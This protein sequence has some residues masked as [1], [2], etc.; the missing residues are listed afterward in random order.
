MVHSCRSTLFLT[1]RL[2]DQSAARGHERA[3]HGIS[4]A[5]SRDGEKRRSQLLPGAAVIPGDRQRNTESSSSG[6]LVIGS[7]RSGLLT[8]SLAAA[9]H[10]LFHGE[11]RSH[12]TALAREHT[13]R[14]WTIDKRLLDRISMS[15][16]TFDLISVKARIRGDCS[17]Y[18]DHVSKIT[19]EY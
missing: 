14:R 3:T 10:D 4:F 15:V 16:V 12:P 8:A 17:D 13:F 11:S 7:N 19:E 9:Y 6:M 18:A 5:R 1:E 2:T